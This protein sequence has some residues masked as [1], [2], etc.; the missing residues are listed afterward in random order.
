LAVKIRN[1][2]AFYFLI[3]WH[4]VCFLS[5]VYAGLHAH[6]L[7]PYKGKTVEQDQSRAG[8]IPE[9]TPNFFYQVQRE[10]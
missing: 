5:L 4:D 3:H 1:D 7:Y 6:S 8:I 2:L 10:W 9:Y